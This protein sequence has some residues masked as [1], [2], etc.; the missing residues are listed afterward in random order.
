M[1]REIILLVSL[2]ICTVFYVSPVLAGDIC[3]ENINTVCIGCHNADEVCGTLGASEK[4]WKA[5]LV[6]MIDNGAE[7]EDDDEEAMGKG[8]IE[9]SAGAKAAC[10]K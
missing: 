10:G 2:V 4:T 9:P 6:W 3:E 8:F 5:V 1:S 7:L